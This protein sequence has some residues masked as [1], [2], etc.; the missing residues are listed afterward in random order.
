MYNPEG[1]LCYLEEKYLFF[2]GIFMIYEGI[3]M[4]P[5]TDKDVMVI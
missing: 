3:V 5:D 1:L 4:N 2:R